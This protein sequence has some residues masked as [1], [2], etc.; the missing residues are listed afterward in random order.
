MNIKTKKALASGALAISLGA[1]ALGV[2]G[3]SPALA[4]SQATDP[5]G[6]GDTQLSASTETGPW[7]GWYLTDV[8]AELEL[9]PVN[10]EETTY[11]GT[12]IDLTVTDPLGLS[13][14]VGGS[15]SHSDDT[16][17]CSWYG[18]T[19]KQAVEVS[20]TADSANFMATPFLGDPD[21]S[22]DFSLDSDNR[23]TITVAADT[24]FCNGFFVT[25]LTY[26]YGESLTATPIE[27]AV[28][29]EVGTTD[30]CDWEVT[31][32]TSIPAGLVPTY[33]GDT[34]VYTGPT[35]TTT[36]EIIDTF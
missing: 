2:A 1:L 30:R 33:G 19:N 11:V 3:V 9:V 13:A 34:Y 21:T 12:A 16:S 25:D 28:F 8:S 5:S 20:V 27:S 36:L 14:F 7:C 35:L 15:E 31:Y 23:L 6:G 4:T 26:I 10:V 29:T 24:D 17:N 22:M 32:S 18:D